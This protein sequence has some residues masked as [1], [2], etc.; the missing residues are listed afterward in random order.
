MGLAE[1]SHTRQVRI[2]SPRTTPKGLAVSVADLP[3][4]RELMPACGD[5]AHPWRG[6][7]A[8]SYEPSSAEG[9]GEDDLRN[10]LVSSRVVPWTNSSYASSL[11]SVSRSWDT[12]SEVPRCFHSSIMAGA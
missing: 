7:P 4:F 6:F 10:T 5:E 3:G 1:R 11:I 12:F 2:T 8:S 9:S